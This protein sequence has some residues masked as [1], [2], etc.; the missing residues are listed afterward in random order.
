MIA[1]GMKKMMGVSILNFLFS[2]T[3]THSATTS[4]H[5]CRI[6]R[7]CRPLW[8]FAGRFVIFLILFYTMSCITLIETVFVEPDEIKSSTLL[9]LC[10]IILPLKF[11]QA[12]HYDKT[13][14]AFYTCWKGS[15]AT[16]SS[17]LVVRLNRLTC[18]YWRYNLWLFV[19]FPWLQPTPSASHPGTPPK[20]Q[21]SSDEDEMP[22]VIFY[23]HNPLRLTGLTQPKP[24]R[25]QLCYINP[26]MVQSRVIATTE[27]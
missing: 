13:C 6:F 15:C 7:C 3:D 10:G 17:I 8:T 12:R 1:N 2:Y 14:R 22:E 5:S 21:M 24:L 27:I 23:L 19:G 26:L 11:M 4:H 16:E 20:R 25:G 18:K 9:L